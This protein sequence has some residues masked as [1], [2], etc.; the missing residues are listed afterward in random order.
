MS[1]D[2]EAPV[3]LTRTAKGSSFNGRFSPDSKFVSFLADRGDKT[4]IYIISV[5]GGEAMQVTKDEDGVNVYEW[6]P[7]GKKIA[8]LKAEP[9]SKK[10][11]T[12]KDRFG[13]FGV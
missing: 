13:A 6:S 12:I 10:D 4:Q 2:G 9:D 7:D 11:K 5:N 3:Q 1:R 8:Y